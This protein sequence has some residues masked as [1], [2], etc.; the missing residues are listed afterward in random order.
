MTTR[1]I[2]RGTFGFTMKTAIGGCIA[3][4]ALPAIA[5]TALAL[6][7]AALAAS[8]HTIPLVPPASNTVQQG[9][10]RIINHS[11]RAGT[12][13]I[14][15][16]DDSGRRFGP[17]SMSLNAKTT[18]HLNSRDLE[19]GNAGKGLSEGLGD[20]SGN[21]RLEFTSDLDIEPLAHVRTA[22]LLIGMQDVVAEEAPMRYRVP[23]FNPGSNRSRQSRL[24][25]INPNDSDT[26]VTIT[27]LDDQGM[28]PPEG[29]VRLT[30]P[31]GESR[32]ITA[33]QLE[34][35]HS[36][37]SGRFG[38]GAGKWQLFVSAHRSIQVMNLM[39]NTADGNLTNLSRTFYEAPAPG[40]CDETVT[41]EGND[42]GTHSLGTAIS[43]GDLTGVGNVRARVG[44]VNRTSNEADYYRFT[45]TDPDGGTYTMRFELRNL[46]GN[47]DI[48]LLN[49]S[50]ELVN[51]YPH[52]QST[53]SGTANES[54]VW[55]LTSRPNTEGLYY[56]L[57]TAA[58]DA[59]G[60][61]G[62][63][64]RYS[65]DSVVPGRR[66]ESA[67][68]L[69]DMARVAT[70]RMREGDEVNRTHNE[71]CL[72]RHR[73]YRFTL[74]D[75]DGGA[76][77]M[78]FELRNL[79]GNADIYLLNSSGEL[80]NRYPH[81]Q[82]TNSGTANES[83]VWTLTSR[84]NNEGLYYIGVTAAD[85]ARGTVGYQLRYSNDSVVP[86]RRIESAFDLGDL[87]HVATART[88]EGEVNRSRNETA[89]FSDRYYRFTLTDPDGGAYTMRFELRNLTGNAD[90]YLL[91]SSGEL[92]NRYP[93][94]QSTNSGTANESIVWT[95]TSRPNT[96]GLYYIRVTAADD[97]HGTI[98]YQLRYGLD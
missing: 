69:G 31:A 35:G 53:N 17:V 63:Q 72:F 65:N 11:D 94:T 20:G 46:T 90:I 18:V 89:L 96:E 84:P 52:T 73:Y 92:V 9:F 49:S 15:A 29:N 40:A 67:F 60:T 51:R 85:D 87:T 42:R 34:S 43:L 1:W 30:L 71:T 8:M 62:Y 39:L 44:E 88:R 77:T 2:D 54:I 75:P 32:M 64:L 22:G 10:I 24:R 93:H 4:G 7:Q 26:E 28:P 21:W 97:A 56:I 50:G 59:R 25:L 86:G 5:I 19:Q 74:T 57:V 81:T 47:A 55:T 12:V 78:R 80:V 41:V 3:R 58:D 68:D 95:L 27:G 91:N 61:V 23:T 14:R 79:T 37:L 82:S 16:T 66:I 76:Y 13:I 48:Y 83:I 36:T 98:G 6:G 38:D 45:L 33:Q 70:V